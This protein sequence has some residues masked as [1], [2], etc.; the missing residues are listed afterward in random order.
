[1]TKLSVVS[2]WYNEDLLAEM[3]LKHYWYADEIH[4]ILD[5]ATNDNTEDI[6]KKDSRVLIHKVTYPEGLVWDEKQGYVNECYKAIDEGWVIVVDADEF[7]Y[8]KGYPNLKDYLEKNNEYDIFWAYLYHVY[9]HRFEP[10][11]EKFNCV[12]ERT[13]GIGG[14]PLG[15]VY[16]PKEPYRKPIVVKAGLSPEW[17]AGC[18]TYSNKSLRESDDFFE[19]AHWHMA[20]KKIAIKRRLQTKE[21]LAPI[22]FIQKKGV[23]NFD[24]SIDDIIKECEKNENLPLVINLGLPIEQ[25]K[26]SIVMPVY[27]N[28]EYTKQCME[29][30]FK[31]TNDVEY[32]VIVVNDS[33]T[34]DTINYINNLMKTN[35]NIRLINNEKNL[36][37]VKSCNKGVENAKYDYVVVINN[38]ILV[39]K[40]WLSDLLDCFGIDEKIAFV[41]PMLSECSGIQKID[42]SY[43]VEDFEK[44]AKDFRLNNWGQF[45]YTY[46]LIFSCIVFKKD[47]F[48]KLGKLDEDFSPGCFED[49]DICLRTFLEGYDLVVCKNVLV[50]HFCSKTF[51]EK[52]YLLF[53]TNVNKFLNKWEKAL[54]NKETFKNLPTLSVAMIVK[55][56]AENLKRLLPKIRKVVD[57]IV[58]VD[59]GSTDGT[60]KV[61]KKYADRVLFKEWENDFSKARNYSLENCTCDYIIWLDAD[62]DIDYRTIFDLKL[63]LKLNPQT[64]VFML[65]SDPKQSV[66][67]LQLRVFPNRKEI[68]FSGRI[69]EQVAKTIENLRIPLTVTKLP[70]IHLGYSDNKN[71]R[72]KLLRNLEILKKEPETSY[73]CLNLARTYFGL[74][75][76]EEALQHINKAIPLSLKEEVSKEVIASYYLVKAEILEKLNVNPLEIIEVLEEALTKTNS[77]TIK[78][79]LGII[80]FRMRKYKRAYNLLVNFVNKGIHHSMIP[81]NMNETQTLMLD[82]LLFSSLYVGDFTTA[83]K[84]IKDVL[85]D[86]DFRIEK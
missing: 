7:V 1:M 51:G 40:N 58:V 44:I 62:D 64:A 2:A 68:R 65:I 74:G 8:K 50:H 32:E 56:E 34:D 77:P 25:K 9:K 27:N 35:K 43:D 26:V 54:N 67:Y 10:E 17:D 72:N 29:S 13:H 69:H 6:L 59:T 15:I 19:G 52:L 4:I 30:I 11:L 63:H 48:L 60:K 28:L 18:H 81:M 33:S 24:V 84:V 80:N 83:E 16:L 20:D 79:F 37:F 22:N 76:Y 41:A 39:A 49:D 38:D 23:Q 46:R 42:F 61:A 5:S 45:E 14:L 47:I 73:V 71:I 21:R 36:G 85:N 86:S 55:N 66:S 75:D 3:F 82:G 31:N 78:V 57:E 70:I 53:N 12:F